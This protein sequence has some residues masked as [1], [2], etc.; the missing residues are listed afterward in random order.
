MRISLQSYSIGFISGVLAD[1]G[2]RIL[3]RF[4]FTLR[5]FIDCVFCGPKLARLIPQA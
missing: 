1:E 3:I 5:R 4:F 2:Y